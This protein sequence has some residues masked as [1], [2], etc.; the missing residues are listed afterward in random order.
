MA[1]RRATHLPRS[2]R[3]R[4]TFTA[5]EL[6]A[7]FSQV[8]LEAA[9]TRYMGSASTFALADNAIAMKEK[10]LGRSSP[11]SRR[12]LFWDVLPW[13]KEAYGLRRPRYVF[14]PHDLIVSLLNL[15]FT[16]VH[17]T[18]PILHRPSFER[19]VARGLHLTDVEF[20]G[21]LLSVLAV[22]SR[23]SNDPRVFVDGDTSLSGGFKYASQLQILRKS[24]N[25]SIYQV[26]MYC[27]LT[28]FALG[29]SLPQSSWLYT[30]LGIRFLQQRGEHRRKPEV[31][32]ANAEDELW[33]RAFWSFIALERTVCLF[34]GRPM[35]LH[36]E[37]YDTELPLEVDDEYWD[38]G[39]TQPPGTPSQ[40]SFFICHLRLGEIL[41]DAMRRLYGTKKSKLMMGWDGPEWEQRAV[42]ELD[43]SLND[44]QDSIPPHLRWDPENPPQDTFFDQSAT[45]HITYNYARIVIHRPYIQ[46]VAAPA[47]PPSLSICAGAA[48][49][50][51][52]T[53]DIWLH[54]LQRP[55]LPYLMNPVFVSGVILVLYMLSTKGAGPIDEKSK[56]LVL[57]ATAVE[58]HKF[59]ES[60]MQPVGSLTDLLRELWLLDRPLP[61]KNSLNTEDTSADAVAS[62]NAASE[63]APSTSSGILVPSLECVPEMYPHLPTGQ[64]AEFWNTDEAPSNQPLELRPGMSIE[65]LL[66]DTEPLGTI[67]S[68]LNGELMAMWMAAPTDMAHVGEW[69]AYIENMNIN[70]N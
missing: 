7:R 48:R 41:G 53:T 49:S 3:T 36:T 29:A 24:F 2:L 46:K 64:P 58:V 18:I 65:Q 19:S 30:G 26:Q 17:P 42:A 35:G 44:F 59:A 62:E 47:G 38:Q 14:P 22:A 10:Y 5:D 39:F 27:L 45:L 50:I 16:N 37:E 1:L 11:P 31:H 25:P 32:E 40:L 60:R 55:P 34:L 52:H 56:D 68:I 70:V 4:K 57:V 21:T 63:S 66:A 43:S 54:K 13:E 51:I 33:K 61:L 12:P 23:Y 69:D 20:G 8:S 9:R 6:A 67:D 15:Y 28:L